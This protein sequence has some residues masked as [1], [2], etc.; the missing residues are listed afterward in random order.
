MFTYK[1]TYFNVVRLIQICESTS[2]Y[3]MY[4]V[5]FFSNFNKR[6]VKNDQL[7]YINF[8]YDL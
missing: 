8:S 1:N 7:E 2:F 4:Y 3:L 5:Y 6:Y